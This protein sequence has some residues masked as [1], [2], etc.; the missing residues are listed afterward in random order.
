MNAD[1][2]LNRLVSRGVAREVRPGSGVSRAIRF[3]H[4][5]VA[6]AIDARER[7]MRARWKE[8]VGNSAISYLLI[9]DDFDEDGSVLALGPSRAY[10]AYPLP[11]LHGDWP[12]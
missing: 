1:E 4:I 9:A 11:R 7:S 2:L 8:R 6:T 5:E 10:R 12:R 3:G